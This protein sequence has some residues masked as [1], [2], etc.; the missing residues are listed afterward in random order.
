VLSDSPL[1]QVV[2]T[3]AALRAPGGCPWDREQ[4]HQSLKK[5][6][7]QEVYELVEALD[8]RHPDRVCDE[9][10]D[11]LLQVLFHAQL[12]AERGEFDI[13]E[14]ARR[15]D[16]KLKRRHPHVFGDV[17][18]RGSADVLENWFHL[19]QAEHPD[20]ARKS[21]MEGIA[22]ELPA[23]LKAYEVQTKA[24]QVGFDWDDAAGPMHKVLE[25]AREVEDAAAADDAEAVGAELG[26]LLFAVVNVARKLNVDPE[27]ALRR[28]ADRFVRRF[29]AIEAEAERQ[30]RSVSEM[31]LQEMDAVW[32]AA[33][34][35]AR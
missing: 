8:A 26:D 23:L 13:Y 14:V 19:K 22:K 4:D 30:G 2:A 7:L 12:A 28:T 10:G 15:L 31:S 3:M 25:E 21:R 6:L 9:L 16:A 35:K 11:L 34:D 27:D 24:A 32:D 20:G 29:Q 5:Y 17:Q 18:V 33:K 1:E